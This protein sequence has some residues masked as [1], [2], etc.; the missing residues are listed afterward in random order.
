MLI[1]AAAVAAECGAERWSWSC[2]AA[3]AVAAVAWPETAC[4]RSGCTSL[5]DSAY[6]RVSASVTASAQ[7]RG[8]QRRVDRIAC[9]W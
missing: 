9:V 4:R 5:R 3:A 1:A 7:T 6:Q 2:P 8:D